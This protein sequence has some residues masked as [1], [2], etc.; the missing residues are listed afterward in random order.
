[1]INN[2]IDGWFTSL[3]TSTFKGVIKTL[4]VCQLAG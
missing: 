2:V 4:I 3:P 1:M